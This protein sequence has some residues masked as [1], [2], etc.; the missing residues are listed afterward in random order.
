MLHRT[1]KAE[2][3]TISTAFC[4]LAAGCGG[5]TKSTS[6]A[7]PQN[8]TTPSATITG[9]QQPVPPEP[10]NT[11]TS[12]PSTTDSGPQE[13]YS[14]A[15]IPGHCG[16]VVDQATAIIAAS[17]NSEPNAHAYRALAKLCL[18]QDA[19]DDLALARG[20]IDQLTAQAK[21]LITAVVAAGTPTGQQLLE[22]VRAN[23]AH[24]NTP[25]P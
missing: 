12:T 18:G 1:Q 2:L 15:I 3:A 5:G 22:V 11:P 14:P 17:P 21:M 19:S 9:P 16:D 25:S 20:N 6:P 23:V 8:P 7:E 4:L 24:A 10:A 13:P